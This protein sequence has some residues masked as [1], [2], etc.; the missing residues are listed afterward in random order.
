MEEDKELKGIKKTS[1]F[2]GDSTK[3]YG[4]EYMDDKF[5]DEE[6]KSKKISKPFEETHGKRIWAALAEALQGKADKPM[7]IMSQKQEKALLT[8]ELQKENRREMLDDLLGDTNSK[9]KSSITESTDDVVRKHTEKE[10]AKQSTEYEKSVR[11]EIDAY[12]DTFD[13]LSAKIADKEDDLEKIVEIFNASKDP[14]E[15]IELYA[16]ITQ[17]MKD[18]QGVAENFGTEIEITGQDSVVKGLA[19]YDE[20][21]D[22]AQKRKY[23]KD[24]K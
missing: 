16:K 15:K 2:V 8:P 14:K 12:K 3:L 6:G 23:I 1:E 17:L 13:A 4:E 19:N 10:F 11:N 20:F 22:E 21:Y 24:L 18:I 5:I 7:P 9:I